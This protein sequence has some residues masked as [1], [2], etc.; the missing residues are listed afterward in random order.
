LLHF[1]IGDKL[2]HPQWFAW[3]P[4]P[5][6]HWIVPVLAGI[7]FGWGALAVFLASITYLVDTYQVANGASAVAANGLLRFTLGAV[8]P[9][10]TIQMYE[11]LGIHWAGSLFAFISV[12]LV[13]V[14]W[15]FFWKGRELRKKSH[16]DTVD[17]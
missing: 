14:P 12:L 8:F 13:P 10:F 4:R 1:N 6:V 7:P 16:Y 3:A 2:I 5:S 11:K 17:Y 9:L 15:I